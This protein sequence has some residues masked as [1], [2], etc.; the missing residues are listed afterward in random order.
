MREDEIGQVILEFKA[1]EQIG[2]VHA[3]LG[4]TRLKLSGLKLGLS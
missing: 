4:L 1:I 2:K 3:R